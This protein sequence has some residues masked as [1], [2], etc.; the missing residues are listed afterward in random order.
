MAVPRGKRST[1]TTKEAATNDSDNGGGGGVGV[2]LPPPTPTS[3][4]KSAI[5]VLA[6]ADIFAAIE[7]SVITPRPLLDLFYPLPPPSRHHRARD[8]DVD[9][10]LYDDEHELEHDDG[11]GNDDNVGA[12]GRTT[13]NRRRDAILEVVRDAGFNRARSRRL[14]GGMMTA[15]SRIVDGGDYLPPTVDAREIDNDDVD[16][17]MDAADDD[18]GMV[19]AEE[20][21]RFLG[22]CASLVEAYLRG[23]LSRQKKQQRATTSS[24]SQMQQQQ[25]QKKIDVVDEA[26]EVAGT[27]HDLLFPLQQGR[28]GSSCASSFKSRWSRYASR[29]QSAIFSMCETWWYGNFVDRERMVTQLVP[30]LLVR[31]LDVDAKRDDVRRLC[32]VRTAIDLLDFDDESISSLKIHLLRTVGHP[33][34]LRCPEGRRFVGHLFL[35]DASFVT[36]VHGAVKA[37][38]PGAKKSV[39]EAYA[40]IYYGAWK[41]STEMITNDGDRRDN[42]VHGG[43][44]E[45]DGERGNGVLTAAANAMGEIQSSIEENALQDLMYHAMHA[46]SPATAKSARAVLDRFH[47]NKKAHD[48]ESMLHRTYGPLLWRGLSSA[49]ARVR[50]RACAVLAD[51]FPLRDPRAGDESTEAVVDRSVGALVKSMKDEVPCVRVAGSAA[52]AR[53]L[54]CF[55]AMIPIAH[56]R[57]LL[58]HIVAIHASD[59]SSPAVR[60]AAVDAV[61][62]LLEN[63]MTHAVLRPLLPSI[64]NLIHDKSDKVRLAVV[65]MLLLVKKIR[66]MKYYHVV[67]ANHLLARLADEGHGRN[68]PRGPVARALSDLLSNSFFPTGSKTTMTDIVNRTIRLLTDSPKAAVVFYRN[69]SSQLSVHS[70][71]KLIAALTKC[72][73]YFVIEEKKKSHENVNGMLLAI[74]E[75]ESIQCKGGPLSMAMMATIA[76]GVSIL[77]ESIDAKLRE[78]GNERAHESLVGVFSGK[79]LT[80]VYFHFVA[81][82]YDIEPGSNEFDDCSRVVVA[83]LNCAGKLEEG[84]CERLRAGIIDELRKTSDSST[85]QSVNADLSPNIALLCQWGMMEDVVQCLA[86]SIRQH[87]EGNASEPKNSFATRMSMDFSQRKERSD[88]ANVKNLPTLSIEVCL[89]ILGH[90]LKGSH[91]ASAS[92]RASILMSETAF[93]AISSALLTS[94]SAAERMIKAGIA[95]NED[96]RLLRHL[97]VSLECYGRFLIHESSMKGDLPVKLTPALKSLLKWVTVTVVPS[98]V[99]LVDQDN[100][101][102]NLDVSGIMCVGS[103][104]SAQDAAGLLDDLPFMD[105]GRYF[106]VLE[107]KSKSLSSLVA[108]ICCASSVIRIFAE[109]LLIRSVGDSFVTE[110]MTKICKLLECSDKTVRNALLPLIFHTAIICLEIDGDSTLF[111]RILISMKTVD[112]SQMEEDI[113]SHYMSV[114]LAQRDEHLLKAAM[115]AIARVTHTILLDAEEIEDTSM[116]KTPFIEKVGAFM[117]KVIEHVLSE[118]RSSLLLAQCIFNKNKAGALREWL[119][120]ELN[121]RSPKTEALNEILRRWALEISSK[122]AIH[123]PHD[124]KE[125]SNIN[126]NSLL[127]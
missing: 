45:E 75:V 30:L 57:T 47:V 10:S 123:A 7:S 100:T 77:W 109:W 97:G 80:E 2:V 46:S 64:G 121:E 108:V 19:E 34:F 91:P 85:K 26:F 23:V 18:D 11:G 125:N 32:A 55:W 104:I 61:A 90:V 38:I 3:T 116:I 40:E 63:N 43:E 16:D 15:I 31:S 37:Q 4:T 21:V 122:D 42:R 65:N 54:G 39:L 106:N 68:D 73:C 27:L 87:F 117:G 101:L 110:Q 51:T 12:A 49:N 78:S 115:S 66:G 1:K 14:F 88:G 52:T 126:Q 58:N 28:Q 24:S 70:I 25:Q 102:M 6:H 13:T 60:A 56:I 59:A 81:K 105:E 111:E 89:G 17:A 62:I 95:S 35:V 99:K 9:D 93:V 124:D 82:F 86:S 119:F 84:R 92:L 22:C 44:E 5:A 48:V 8:Y 112:S 113:V 53:I 96:L 50:T 120:E 74:P 69:A 71:S 72:L 118:K 83:T 114:V 33:L 103:P 29:T 127:N 76:E 98:L 41:A 67:P 107:D 94:K 20:S 79:V 36:E